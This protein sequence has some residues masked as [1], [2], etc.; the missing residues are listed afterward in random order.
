MWCHHECFRKKHLDAEQ[1]RY[2]LESSSTTSQPTPQ[3]AVTDS[4]PHHF[5]AALPWQATRSNG[6]IHLKIYVKN[7]WLGVLHPSIKK[8]KL[9]TFSKALLKVLN[10]LLFYLGHLLLT[11]STNS[12]LDS[13][14]PFLILP[15]PESIWT[16]GLVNHF[17][18]MSQW[19]LGLHIHLPARRWL[20][21]MLCVCQDSWIDLPKS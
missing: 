8:F 15:T 20:Q 21:A 9:L 3:F 16:F 11:S 19:R 12:K 5:E 4:L 13:P 2:T 7:V 18:L 17:M 6:G 1:I 14:T 10:W